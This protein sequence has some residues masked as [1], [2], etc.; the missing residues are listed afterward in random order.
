MH[1]K[2]EMLAAGLC[3]HM[4]LKKIN[5]TS[6]MSGQRLEIYELDNSSWR[7]SFLR[8]NREAPKPGRNPFDPRSCP[9][10]G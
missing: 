9:C 8:N 5:T 7:V 4:H 10:P 1:P 6:V 3:L 2:T